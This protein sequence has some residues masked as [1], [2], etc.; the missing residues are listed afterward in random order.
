VN[1]V[2]LRHFGAPLVTSTFEFGRNGGAPIHPE[3]LDTLAVGF[4]NDGWSLR[5][6]HRLL[7][8]SQ[9]YRRDSSGDAAALAKDPENR[10][11]WRMNVRRME[12]EAVRDGV[13]YLAGSLDG[14]RGGPE[15]DQNSALTTSRRSLYY[16]HAPEKQAEFLRL[17][18]AANVNECYERSESIV[19]QQALA[20]A[21][22]V[23]VETQSKA[24]AGK[25]PNGDGF[26][27]TAFRS[28]LGRPPS[29]TE[30]EECARF[31]G[32]AGPKGREGLV[33]VLFNH[34]DFVTIR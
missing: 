19:P 25:L 23:L 12:S 9:A 18:D 33:H 1:H 11:L 10:S 20:L 29:P 5:K 3:L 14:A 22:S 17:F 4:M 21:N 30:R 31:L 28:V 34:N 15:L 26:V 32:Q 24:L 8:T 16:R 2:W 7:V 6:L 27:E 13:L